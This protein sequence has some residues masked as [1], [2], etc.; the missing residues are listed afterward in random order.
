MNTLIAN[1]QFIN[2]LDIS[3]IQ[4]DSLI[5]PSRAIDSKKLKVE[6]YSDPILRVEVGTKNDVLFTSRKDYCKLV[7][8]E[9]L[10]LSLQ[11]FDK[12]R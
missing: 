12:N 2:R 1:P 5:G 11:N 10:L 6:L 7:S 3:E 8:A 4:I 9:N